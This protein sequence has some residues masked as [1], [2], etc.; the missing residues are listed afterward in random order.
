MRG[1]FK[2]EHDIPIPTTK[3][4]GRTRG[5]VTDELRKLA[6]ARKGDSLF[7]PGDR[8]K[9][10]SL[11][12]LIL[13]AAKGKWST[14]RAVEGGYRVWKIAEPTAAPSVQPRK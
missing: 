4:V 11:G 3:S 9:R 14:L 1:E 2:I 12:N 6:A 5:G 7:I 10:T 8:V 13:S